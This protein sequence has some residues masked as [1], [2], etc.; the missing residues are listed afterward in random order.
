MKCKSCLNDSVTALTRCRLQQRLQ[1]CCIGAFALR[2][3]TFVLRLSTLHAQDSMSIEAGPAHKAL[4][5][6]DVQLH[7]STALLQQHSKYIMLLLP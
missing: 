6:Y 3:S 7:N 5:C 1:S 2:L 4:L